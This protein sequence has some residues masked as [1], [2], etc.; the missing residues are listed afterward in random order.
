MNTEDFCKTFDQFYH[1]KTPFLFLVDFN[2][3]NLFIKDLASL[4]SDGDIL[5]NFN[6]ITNVTFK[7]NYNGSIKI[8]STPISYRSYLASFNKV[9]KHLKNGDSY[10]VN[11]TFPTKLSLNISLE[12]IFYRAHAMYKMKFYDMFVFFSPEQFVTIN[13]AKI[14]TYPMKGTKLKITENS[15]LELLQDEK[16][17]AEHITIVDLL[18]NDL[19][20]IAKDVA[21]EQF[22]YISYIN[23]QK[24]VLI[25]TSS[26]I[27]GKLSPK[28]ISQKI[29]QI[30]PAGSVT[31]APKRKTLEIIK[32]AE[33][34]Y[35]GFYTGIA[36][37]FDGKVLDTCVI[38]RYI[39]KRDNTIYYRSGGGITIYSNPLLEYKE[40]LE[41]IYVP[42][43]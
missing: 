4:A 5:Y 12:E 18:R 38:I 10:L 35:R 22:R 28:D 42:T 13:D 40:M 32:T 37:I 33:I 23:T 21:V 11:L 29:L 25:Q 7:K 24:G 19:N 1:T 14:S 39:E 41:K 43:V 17:L 6:G 8:S 26:K 16:E 31:G 9:K 3:Q 27:S 2:K 36:G 20:M 15:E 30:L 34:D